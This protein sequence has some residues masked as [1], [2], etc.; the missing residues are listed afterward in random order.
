MQLAQPMAIATDTRIQT[1][2]HSPDRILVI[3]PME[4]KDPVAVTG[5]IDKRLFTGDNKL[6]A[7]MDTQTSLWSLKYEQGGLPE[8]LKQRFTSIK[9]LMDFVTAYFAKRNVEI[10]EVQDH[11][12]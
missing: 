11:H 5:I 10:K 8:P 2:M 4:G 1:K 6:H 7:I 3:R 9:K 12:A